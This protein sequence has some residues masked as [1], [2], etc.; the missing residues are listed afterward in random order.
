MKKL[1]ILFLILT[2]NSVY[3]SEICGTDVDAKE[4][5]YTEVLDVGELKIST[6]AV[7]SG[8][9]S[10]TT[11]TDVATMCTNTIVA[12]QAFCASNS[13]LTSDLNETTA[14]HGSYCWCRRTNTSIDGELTDSIGTWVLIGSSSTCNRDCGKYCAESVVT[15]GNGMR[16]AIML[17]PQF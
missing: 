10:A 8:C 6:W 17:M 14:T 11:N 16:N 15:N 2:G 4:Y 3:G 9:Y 7:G 13:W 5:S 1:F 12:G